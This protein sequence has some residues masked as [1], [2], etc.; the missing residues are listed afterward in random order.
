MNLVECGLRKDNLQLLTYKE[1]GCGSNVPLE[2]CSYYEYK[3]RQ[4]PN[5]KKWEKLFENSNCKKVIGD[6][7]NQTI[8]DKYNVYTNIDKKRI[9]ADYKYNRNKKIFVAGMTLIIVLGI[10]I[11]KNK[12]I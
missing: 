7:F 12:K 10:I 11:I 8:S 3:M 5:E 1:A 4:L 6:Y 9:D 2:N